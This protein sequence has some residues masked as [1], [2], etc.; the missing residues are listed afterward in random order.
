MSRTQADRLMITIREFWPTATLRRGFDAGHI[1]TVEHEGRRYN[2]R[3]F[4]DW[5]RIRMGLA[6]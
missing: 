1:V 6:S 3:S 4:N 2:V 5:L